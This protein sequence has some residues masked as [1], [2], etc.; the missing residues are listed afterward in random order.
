MGGGKEVLREQ[1]AVVQSYLNL[2]RLD[3]H[4]GAVSTSLLNPRARIDVNLRLVP[5]RSARSVARMHSTIVRRTYI[6]S[7]CT[8]YTRAR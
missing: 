1:G 4:V 7:S 6:R 2:T 3:E 8:D 5:M